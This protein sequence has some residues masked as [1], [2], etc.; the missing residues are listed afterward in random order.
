MHQLAVT[1]KRAADV[2]VLI[3]GQ[4][5][6]IHRIERDEQ[7]IADLIA[8]ERAFWQMVETRQPPPAD[9]TESA[10]RALRALFPHDSGETLDLAD[11]FEMSAAFSDL[12]AVRRVLAEHNALE[13]RLKQRIQQRMAT[14]T[15][16]IFDGGEVTWKRSKDSN[17]FDLANLLIDQPGLRQR[18]SLTT[19]GSR[20][21]LVHPKP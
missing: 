6:R 14:A 5:L 2:A 20:R 16:A 11:D 7:A 8:I 15:K 4:E 17:S 13:D 1:G 18:Y 10:D 19:P 21:F 3:C 9:G 12:L